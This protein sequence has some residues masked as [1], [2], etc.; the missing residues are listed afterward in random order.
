MVNDDK[1]PIV[2]PDE[3]PPIVAR[4][5]R[6]ERGEARWLHLLLYLITALIFAFFLVLG[7]RW[8]YH[9]THHTNQVAK[10]PA[11]NTVPAAPSSKSSNQVAAKPSTPSASSNNSNSS[12][13]GSASA[14]KSNSSSSSLPNNGPG[15]TVAIFIVTSLGAA[16]LHYIVTARRVS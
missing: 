3:P 1:K 7:G 4:P 10:A 12:A 5:P 15:D 2:P 13:S 16:A 8:V 6:R 11:T 14:S 9:K